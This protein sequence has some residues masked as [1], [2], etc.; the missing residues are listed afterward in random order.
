MLVVAVGGL[1]VNLVS[2][3]L[4]RNGSEESLNV[5]GAYMEVVADLAGSVGVLVAAVVT[6]TTGWPYADPL[7]GLLIGLWVLPRA[8]DLGRR[9]VRVLTQA[10]PEHIDMV[11]VEA[12]LRRI[13]GV[14][15]VHDLHVWTL[16]SGMDVAT[17]HLRIADGAEPHRLLDEARELLTDGYQISHA[18]LQVEPESHRECVE[19][20]W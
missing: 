2:W 13:G 17:A 8:L 10:A 5:R 20:S 6:M 9:A 3:W 14:V 12:D 1:V 7:A 16:T 11:E 19:A 15:D 4:L 18:T